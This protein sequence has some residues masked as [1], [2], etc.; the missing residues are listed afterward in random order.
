MDI[1]S[2]G[3]GGM[4]CAYAK[5]PPLPLPGNVYAKRLLP[6]PVAL[7]DSARGYFPP[8]RPSDCAAG[9]LSACCASG[10]VNA[11]QVPRVPA[12]G[13]TGSGAF[14]GRF[15]IRCMGRKGKK[16]RPSLSKPKD[17]RVLH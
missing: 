17:G 3:M 4:P 12:Q 14:W 15:C 2:L 10:V 6:P 9:S 5:V 1:T 16:V 7:A 11:S 8:A 13:S